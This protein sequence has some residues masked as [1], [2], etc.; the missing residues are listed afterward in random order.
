MQASV[1]CFTSCFSLMGRN[2]YFMA[3]D[4]ARGYCTKNRDDRCARMRVGDKTQWSVTCLRWQQ[5]HYVSSVRVKSLELRD[6]KHKDRSPGW[7]LSFRNILPPA[8]AKSRCQESP[9]RTGQAHTILHI[10]PA[11]C[12]WG[13]S[14]WQGLLLSFWEGCGFSPYKF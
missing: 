6:H 14:C 10:S 2:S 4:L 8:L 13:A 1:I 7:V 3:N 5:P 11:V 9:G 12:S